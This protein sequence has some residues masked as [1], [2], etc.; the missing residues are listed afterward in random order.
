M[1][2]ITID[3]V[4]SGSI[5]G[6]GSFDQLMNAVDLRL[7]EQFTKGRITTSDYASVYLSAMQTAISQAMQFT[8]TSQQAANQAELVDAQILLTQAQI[9]KV[10]ADIA[11]TNAQ[12]TLTNKQIEK[13]ETEKSV[14]TQ[15]LF[16]EEAQIKDVVDGNTVTGLIGKQKDLYTR[17]ADGFL[18]EAEVRGASVF[19]DLWTVARSTD[20]DDANVALPFNVD[21]ASMDVILEKVAEGMGIPKASLNV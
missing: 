11:L 15:K 20:P 4:V 5:D 2:D 6:T 18:R 14:L 17:Q 3:Q 1:A 21:R 9:D 16:T 13:T 12:L 7:K 8:L 19:K 10:N